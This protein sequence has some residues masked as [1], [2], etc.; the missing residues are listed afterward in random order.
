MNSLNQFEQIEDFKFKCKKCGTKLDSG[1]INISGHYIKCKGKDLHK[2]IKGMH[3]A[4][5]ELNAIAEKQ[6]LKAVVKFKANEIW[7]E[8]DIFTIY[9]FN[10]IHLKNN[11]YIA[12]TT[13]SNED[14]FVKN[15]IIQ[16]RSEKSTSSPYWVIEAKKD[17]LKI[18]PM[19]NG[20]S[21]QPELGEKYMIDL[22]YNVDE[23]TTSRPSHSLEGQ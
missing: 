10:W 5:I 16:F 22:M 11:D 4:L 3:N 18:K 7:T 15:D 17:I 8:E 21:W 12:I 14:Y 9:L 13:N 6:G 1:I 19:E 2:A 20:A 23:E